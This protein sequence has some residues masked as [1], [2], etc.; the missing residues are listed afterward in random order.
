VIR[1]YLFTLTITGCTTSGGA[2]ERLEPTFIEVSGTTD[3]GTASALAYSNEVRT[4]SVSGA[5]LDRD[6]EPYAYDGWVE[7]TAKPGIVKS[8]S[9]A[10]QTEDAWGGTHWYV[11]AREG[12]VQV[13]VD[14]ASGF[15]DTRVWLTAVPDPNVPDEASSMATGVTESFPIQLPTIPELQDVTHLDIDRPYTDSPLSGEFVTIRTADRQV[16]VTDL[17]TKGF[18]AADLGAVGEEPATEAGAY[19]GLYVY[20]F[21]KPEG[22]A[23]GDRLGL[24]GGGVQEYVG[25]T[26]LSFP[27]YESMEG[28]TLPVPD[29]AVLPVDGTGASSACLSDSEPNN[30]LLEA[31]ESSLVTIPSATIPATFKEMPAGQ[32]SHEDF[33]SYADY[34]QWPVDL[35]GGC[36]F[37]VVSNTA[38]PD[39]D[40]MANAGQTVGPI[41]GLL[42][43]VRALGDRWII[44][45]RGP[46]DMPFFESSVS[47][48]EST[49]RRRPLWP[50]PEPA[51]THTPLCEHTHVGDHHAPHKD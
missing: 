38:V 43:Y 5:T 12:S 46:E 50:L 4:I 37:M 29:A 14:V 15:G 21:N 3:G 16:V 20:T 49:E 35:P 9:G 45:V 30:M 6:A 18:W 13:T 26:Q 7:V 1:I 51:G 42:K 34:W 47:G 27:I 39:F 36:K 41:T 32:D 48:D 8:V 23:I 22:V 31:F 24:L 28:E 40:P 25:T 10:T 33:S 2:V 11:R 17:D 44:V 19:R